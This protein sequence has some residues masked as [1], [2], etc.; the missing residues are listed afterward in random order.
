MGE[1]LGNKERCAFNGDLGNEFVRSRIKKQREC[2]KKREE[3]RWYVL[4]S[5]PLSL[6]LSPLHCIN[7]HV[8]YVND[9]HMYAKLSPTICFHHL[10]CHDSSQKTSASHLLTISSVPVSTCMC[11]GVCQCVCV[12]VVVWQVLNTNLSSSTHFSSF[13]H[14]ISHLSHIS[15][16]PIHQAQ[17][18]AQCSLAACVCG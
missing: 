2:T 15:F 7:I 18:K 17:Q 1:Q 3:R 6:P 11:E 9:V 4:V 14:Q 8:R 12:C 10:R 13:K 16:Y 5:F